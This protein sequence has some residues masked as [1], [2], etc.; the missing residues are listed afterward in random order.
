MLQK[1]HLEFFYCHF[2]ELGNIKSAIL[3]VSI[4][5]VDSDFHPS[6]SSRIDMDDRLFSWVNSLIRV[7][8]ICIEPVKLHSFNFMVL[9][10]W[11]IPLWSLLILNH[12]HQVFFE[13]ILKCTFYV[14]S[15]HRIG[16][17]VRW[18][19][20][21]LCVC[22]RS[23]SFCPQLWSLAAATPGIIS[24]LLNHIVSAFTSPDAYIH[25]FGLR[26]DCAFCIDRFMR[27]HKSVHA[28]NRFKLQR[29]DL[30]FVVNLFLSRILA[31]A[32]SL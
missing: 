20:I 23:V 4:R 12:R 17:A 24:V 2:V 30:C 32:H 19:I 8:L 7:C 3:W 21:I 16:H 13:I 15:C 6:I 10:T 14:G 31:C 18:W 27:C 22:P 25:R 26:L 9:L 5:N 11:T 28:S 29:S 1:L